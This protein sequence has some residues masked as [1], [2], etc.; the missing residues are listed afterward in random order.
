[1]TFR[2]QQVRA[3]QRM[4][5]LAQERQWPVGAEFVTSWGRYLIQNGTITKI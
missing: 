3:I 5:T 4:K 1:M 2:A